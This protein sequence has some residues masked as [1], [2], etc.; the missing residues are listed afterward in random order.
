MGCLYFKWQV[1]VS[2]YA[3][4]RS[5]ASAL[6]PFSFLNEMTRSSPA[7]FDKKNNYPI[8]LTFSF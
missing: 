8:Q 3:E 5:L 7:S 6:F 2:L 1:V 4:V